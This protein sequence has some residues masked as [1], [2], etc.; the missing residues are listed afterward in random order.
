M[1]M[2]LHVLTE[3]SKLCVNLNETLTVRSYD[4]SSVS[5]KQLS[6]CRYSWLWKGKLITSGF[7]IG[8]CAFL[9]LGSVKLTKLNWL[10]SVQIPVNLLITYKWAQ[11]KAT[12]VKHLCS[13]ASCS[14]S[15]LVA[16]T[17][18]HFLLRPTLRPRR[19]QVHWSKQWPDLAVA[20]SCGF[21][22]GLQSVYVRAKKVA[23]TYT[24]DTRTL[25]KTNV[26]PEDISWSYFWEFWILF[27]SVRVWFLRTN[28]GHCGW[29]T[30][31]L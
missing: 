11:M 8:D 6:S 7:S 29:R 5:T 20:S 21:A 31:R 14:I 4:F 28:D 17:S 19:E 30:Y 23:F 22:F 3:S 10:L 26:S 9:V 25:D 1:D 13:G 27:S 12:Q 16:L 2:S 24:C 18:V 15:C